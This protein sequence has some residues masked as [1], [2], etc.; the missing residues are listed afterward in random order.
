LPSAQ[1]AITDAPTSSAVP[2]GRPPVVPLVNVVTPAMIG[3]PGCTTV[4]RPEAP[5][6]VPLWSRITS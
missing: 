5:V 6:V 4:P 1:C 3:W 2:V